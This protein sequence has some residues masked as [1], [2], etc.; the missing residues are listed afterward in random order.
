MKLYLGS[1]A[2]S[3]FDDHASVIDAIQGDLSAA[4]GAP[5]EVVLDADVTI[6]AAEGTCI[7]KLQIACDS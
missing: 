4:A 1:F 2:M 3:E 7:D 6:V 5:V